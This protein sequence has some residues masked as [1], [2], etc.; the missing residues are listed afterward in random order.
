MRQ[1]QL[2]AGRHR[3]VAA[4]R[5]CRRGIPA[6]FRDCT[7]L[8][9]QL[10]AE[11]GLPDVFATEF[12]DD[13]GTLWLGGYPSS[14]LAAPPQYVPLDAFAFDAF[15]YAVDLERVSVAGV[16]V[17]VPTTLGTSSILDT[18]TSLFLLPAKAFTAVTAAITS[19]PGFRSVFGSGAANF[20]SPGNCVTL[21][22]S[23]Q[24]LDA[25]LPAMTL[26]FGTSPAVSV[27]APATESYLF[28]SSSGRWCPSL[29]I[30]PPATADFPVASF[31]GLSVMRSD[32]VIYDRANKRAGFAPRAA[33]R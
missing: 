21:T 19:D 1:R 3:R 29:Y 23:K 15:A 32:V 2:D 18:G 24:T 6:R 7:A 9:D 10:I 11:Q 12:C 17:P 22:Q 5:I 28:P 26:V 30:Q 20:F 33:C 31:V 25:T 27:P 8:F 4:R 14:A 16:S 13:H